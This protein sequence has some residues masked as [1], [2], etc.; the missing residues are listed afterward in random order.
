MDYITVTDD[1]S[2][3]EEMLGLKPGQGTNEELFKFETFSF[4]F[5]SKT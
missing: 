4:S 3:R 5:S 1:Y 2:L